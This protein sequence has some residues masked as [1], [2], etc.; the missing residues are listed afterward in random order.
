MKQVINTGK[1]MKK[2][3]VL[4]AI[5]AVNTTVQAQKETAN[6]AFGYNAGLTWNTTQSFACTGANGTPNATLTGL[7]T[8]IPGIALQTDEGCFS[9]SD[10]NGNLLFYSDGMKIWDKNNA[11]MP[12][13][14]GML[15]H[16]S[17]AQSGVILPYPGQKNKFITASIGATQAP[18]Y[19]SVIDMTLN[20]GLGDVDTS[21]KNVSLTGSGGFTGESLTAFKH[22]N[23]TDYWIIAP[24]KGTTTIMNA[25]LVTAAG[26]QST[27]PVKSSLPIT[28]PNLSDPG[29]YMKISPDGKHF[30]FGVAP[31]SSRLII[32]D[33]DS[34]TGVFSNPKNVSVNAY[35][36]EF[37]N[38][39]KYLYISGGSGVKVYDFMALLSNV[40][41]AAKSVLS[42]STYGALQMGP[43]G[44]LYIVIHKT[45]NMG[46]VDNPEEYNALKVY[47]A[48][49][50][51]TGVGR[52]GLPTFASSW[53]TP[54]PEV[55][56]AP[57]ISTGTSE[58]SK[59]IISTLD[60]V[61]VPRNYADYR[62]GS[63]ILESNNKGFVL[64][65]I[66]SPETAIANPVTGMLV[67]DTTVNA[68]KL[69]NGAEWKLLEQA[70]P[71]I[72]NQE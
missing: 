23:G 5:L 67:Y 17:S 31:S 50:F 1:T 33:F 59:T 34:N 70:C 45:K 60:R 16:P 38:S 43:D 65:R 21:Q 41:T 52:L 63:L 64:T 68:L 25:W 44:R 19:Y 3:V 69:Y 51:L 4:L 40:S 48:P 71:Y 37:S 28:T 29:G 62:T 56:Y 42:T 15:G 46:I 36:V 11:L 32:G 9:L 30:A 35:G 8:N 18:V 7:P 26:V 14:S 66:A 24:G 55:C 39:G 58:P 49:S 6:W 2:L 13:G 72:V 22:A 20:G 47:T 12:N 54:L 57:G 61:A 10:H 27:T 53:F